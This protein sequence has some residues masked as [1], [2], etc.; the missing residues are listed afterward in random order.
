LPVRTSQ[1]NFVAP[2]VRAVALDVRLA[3]LVGDMLA[4]PDGERDDSLRSR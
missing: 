2:Y 3:Q 4:L 1:R